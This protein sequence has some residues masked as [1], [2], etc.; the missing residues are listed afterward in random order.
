MKALNPPGLPALKIPIFLKIPQSILTHSFG[1]SA[2]NVQ[3]LGPVA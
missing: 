3:T 1:L 2:T